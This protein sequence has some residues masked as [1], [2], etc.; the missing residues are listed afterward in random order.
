MRDKPGAA[1]PLHRHEL[2]L[3]Y[4]TVS[5]FRNILNKEQLTLVASMEYALGSLYHRENNI[6]KA[7]EYTQLSIDSRIKNN[8]NNVES[9]KNKLTRLKTGTVPTVPIV[10]MPTYQDSDRIMILKA[11]QKNAVKQVANMLESNSCFD[12]S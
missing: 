4:K 5:V 3:V 8:V 7:I 1:L 10:P 11:V 2:E 6:S 12:I 9:A